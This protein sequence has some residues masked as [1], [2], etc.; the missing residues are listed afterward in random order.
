MGDFK[1]INTQLISKD[2]T[3]AKSHP[4]SRKRKRPES[5]QH[6]TGEELP[7]LGDIEMVH[8]KR[9]H[10]RESRLAT[11][12]AGREGRE[13]FTHGHQKMNPH[14]S[15]TNKD[16]MKKKAFTMVKHKIRRK[17]V[18]RSFKEKQVALRNSLLKRSKNARH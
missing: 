16:K 15:T 12:L 6:K 11:V 14:A 2:I 5:D 3:A 18:K 7:K 10:D 1:A 9:L 13:K 8:K 17:T 4:G